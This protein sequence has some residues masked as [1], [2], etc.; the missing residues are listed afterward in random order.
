MIIEHVRTHALQIYGIE[1]Q[2][3]ITSDGRM[4]VNGLVVNPDIPP[5]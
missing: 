2:N 1:A 3:R 5:T 4:H